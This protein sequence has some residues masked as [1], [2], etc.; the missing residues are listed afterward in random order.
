[1]RYKNFKSRTMIKATKQFNVMHCQR[2]PHNISY[3]KLAILFLPSDYMSYSR[4]LY[5]YAAAPLKMLFPSGNKN[6]E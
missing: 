3:N 2:N 5:K 1:M 4:Y 6:V